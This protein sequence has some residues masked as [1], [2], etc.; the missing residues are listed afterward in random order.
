MCTIIV[1]GW[2][3]ESQ[4]KLLK[5]TKALI[6]HFFGVNK[7][8]KIPFVQ[9][10]LLVRRILA[11]S[12]RRGFLHLHEPHKQTL[13]SEI[14]VRDKSWKNVYFSA[15][16]RCMFYT[17]D[18]KKKEKERKKAPLSRGKH[19][20]DKIF[21]LWYFAN[22]PAPLTPT[23]F[24]EIFHFLFPGE[25]KILYR[26]FHYLVVNFNNYNIFKPQWYSLAKWEVSCTSSF[27]YF[28]FFICYRKSTMY[29]SILSLFLKHND[30]CYT[31]GLLQY[32]DHHGQIH[33]NIARK[34]IT[35]GWISIS[36]MN[37]ALP[38]NWQHLSKFLMGCH[39]VN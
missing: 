31:W 23:P 16:I 24:K 30:C 1:L 2:L 3:S 28:G 7:T 10:E 34:F 26:Y 8:Y 39:M 29:I 17:V 27:Y 11:R 6:L 18:P 19:S 38:E 36:Q 20:R 35:S 14:R 12:Q 25:T 9:G 22:W 37:V 5:P 13:H 32:F 21:A 33:S 15:I 4:F